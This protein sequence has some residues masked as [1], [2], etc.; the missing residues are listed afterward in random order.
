MGG[1]SVRCICG[2]ICVQVDTI[3]RYVFASRYVCL[4]VCMPARPS[5]M[6]L[7]GCD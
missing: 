3:Y 5:S 7:K 4:Y 6:S 1:V 2:P